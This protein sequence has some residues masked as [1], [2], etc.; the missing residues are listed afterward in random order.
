MCNTT[1]DKMSAIFVLFYY[2][3]MDNPAKLK[4]FIKK[5]N[6][7]KYEEDKPTFETI[8]ITSEYLLNSTNENI[9]DNKNDISKH[10]TNWWSSSSKVLAIKSPCN[11]GKTHLLKSFMNEFNINSVLFLSNKKTQAQHL[12]EK[13]QSQCSFN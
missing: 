10:I 12:F 2:V 9:K 1:N 4:E 13:S 3:K 5:Y 7:K 6:I 11:T 8:K